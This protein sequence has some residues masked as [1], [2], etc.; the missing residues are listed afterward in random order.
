MLH[1]PRQRSS[2]MVVLI[3]VVMPHGLSPEF[4]LYLSARDP[5]SGQVPL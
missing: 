2:K 4:F 3:S 5:F 1:L